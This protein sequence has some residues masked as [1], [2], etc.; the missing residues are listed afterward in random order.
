MRGTGTSVSASAAMTRY[1]RS[2][3][4]A[5]GNNLPG[6]FLRRTYSPPAVSQ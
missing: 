4:C 5:L 2:T 1:S 6:G 3:S